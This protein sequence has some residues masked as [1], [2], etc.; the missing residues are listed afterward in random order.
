[1]AEKEILTRI[2][3]KYDTQE[4]WNKAVNFVP[5]K[6]ELIIYSDIKKFKVGDGSS[7]LSVLDFYDDDSGS[8]DITAYIDAHISNKENPHSVT[9]QQIG[10]VT[11]ARVT[12]MIND[13]LGVIENG[14]Y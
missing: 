2:Q 1:M 9:A 4:N 10:A 13:A 14:S 12:T 11:E 8:S 6:G 3:H 7:K 5:K